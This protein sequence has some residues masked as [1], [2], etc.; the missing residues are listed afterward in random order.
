MS[1]PEAASLWSVGEIK[2]NLENSSSLVE[3]NFSFSDWLSRS[4]TWRTIKIYFLG[5]L[6]NIFAKKKLSFLKLCLPWHDDDTHHH[7][8]AYP[9]LLP[10]QRDLDLMIFQRAFSLVFS[11]GNVHLWSR[12]SSTLSTRN[13]NSSSCLIFDF[14]IFAPAPWWHHRRARRPYSAWDLSIQT[15]ILP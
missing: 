8:F 2:G 7:A 14:L 6:V 4:G 13:E 11:T 12:E 15:S 5:F 10:S 1:Y 3:K 9:G